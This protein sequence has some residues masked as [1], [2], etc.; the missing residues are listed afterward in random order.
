MPEFED[1]TKLEPLWEFLAF[2]IAGGAALA[3]I[4]F[5]TIFPQM[6]ARSERVIKMIGVFLL[7]GALVTGTCA[8]IISPALAIVVGLGTGLLVM[9][10]PFLRQLVLRLINAALRPFRFFWRAITGVYLGIVRASVA[11]AF[12]ELSPG[13]VSRLDE[14]EAALE[15]LYGGTSRLTI[16]GVRRRWDKVL[17]QV[18][19][20]NLHVYALL[21]SCEPIALEG[22]ELTLGFYYPFHRGRVEEPRAIAVVEESLEEVWG[23]PVKVKCVLHPERVSDF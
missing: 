7:M 13:I 11:R 1:L 20:K 12:P 21:K 16:Y 8:F 2:V 6:D 23:V 4:P 22:N 14:I 15:D 10:L 5:S 3:A 9:S 17:Q 18:E 19:S